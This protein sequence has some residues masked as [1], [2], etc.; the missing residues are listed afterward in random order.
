MS[1]Y[2]PKLVY[3]DPEVTIEFTYPPKDDDGEQFDAKEKTTTA[4]DG[5]RWTLVDYIEVKRRVVLS[6]LTDA[7]IEALRTFYVSHAS[8]GG[9]FKWFED[10]DLPSFRTYQ[11]DRNSFQA[12]RITATGPS[13]WIWEC[14]LDFRRVY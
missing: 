14:S 2:I 9:Y 10:K 8:L 3:G 4:L 6:F 1:L 13:S 5:T 11:L 12:N 7:Q